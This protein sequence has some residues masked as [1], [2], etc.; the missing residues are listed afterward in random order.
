MI[1]AQ[2][3]KMQWPLMSDGITA[4]DRNCLA[5]FI[6]GTDKLTMGPQVRAFEDAW[7]NWQGCKYA[8][9][10]NSGS[11]ANLL[12]LSAM[13]E[14]HG[15]GL[16]VAC[17]AITWATNIAPVIQMG[18]PL[19]LTDISLTNFGPDL[20]D[21]ERVLATGE[22][23]FLFLTHL[24]GFPAITRDLL[25]L[26]GRH[27]VAILEDCCEAHGASFEGVKVG[28]FGIGSTF[29]FY[30]GHHMTTIEGGMACTDDPA[31]YRLL[32]LLRSHG[33]LRELPRA[34][35]LPGLD[36]RFTFLVPGYN[37]RPTEING[38]LGLRQLPRLDA[39]ILRRNANLSSWLSSLDMHDFRV[40]FDRSG[41]SS[42][43]LPLLLTPESRWNMST[44][45]ASLEE[46]GVESRPIV[47]GNISR[48]PFLAAH[49]CRRPLPTADYVHENG[50]YVGNDH[51][52]T[53]E[54]VKKLAAVLNGGPR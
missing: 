14:L 20:A 39:S 32:L 44:L 21:L 22:V 11:S 31:V 30:Y 16:G 33:L 48:H 53:S 7:A 10:V 25:D 5:D 38:F 50:M 54:M 45:R 36:P 35:P 2:E 41:V 34:E 9:M 52:V 19:H 43:S 28:N 4:D 49:P 3:R 18:M 37:M 46:A 15:A 13:R 27:N 40:D 6:C 29:S 26:C 47:S 8:V 17:Q 51:T 12:L 24:L 23:R 42:F 1:T